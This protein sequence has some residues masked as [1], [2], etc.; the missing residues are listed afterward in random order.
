MSKTI[1]YVDDEPWF[2]D[3]LHEALHNEGYS[4]LKAENGAK[5]IKLLKD[6][7]ASGIIPDL[8]ILDVIM[9]EGESE[10][11]NLKG[12]DGGRRTG[13]RVYEAIRKHLNLTIP[14]IFFTVVDY[15]MMERT[16]KQSERS[17]GIDTI[18][19][20]V[21]PVLPTEL[22]QAVDRILNSSTKRK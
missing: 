17:L 2:V 8:I 3:A 9:P 10:N 11:S 12:N 14:I 5:A 21:K 22:I 19:V 18:S 13:V 15:T 6:S 7:I 4:L 20:L 16:V 1:L